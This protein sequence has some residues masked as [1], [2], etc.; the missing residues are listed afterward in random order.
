MIAVPCFARPIRLKFSVVISPS[1][2]SFGPFDSLPMSPLIWILVAALVV[3]GVIVLV[4]RS[5]A[6]PRVTS[7]ATSDLGHLLADTRR[8]L[9][10]R[11][12][13]VFARSAVS[14]S[15]WEE[16]EEELI[17]SDLGVEAARRIVEAVKR[18]GPVNARQAREVIRTEMVRILTGL[19]RSLHLDSKPAIVVMVGVNGVGKTT[20]VAKLAALLQAEGRH[21][22]IGAADTFRPAADTQLK[23]WADRVGV[24]VVSGQAGGDPAAVAY[25]TLQ[26]ARARGADVVIIDT[27]GRFQT[28]HN[29]MAELAKILRVL[30]KD[31][32]QVSEVLLVMDATTGQ[33]GLPQARRFAELGTTGMILTKMDGTSKGG[34][35][36]AVERELSLPVKFIGVGEGLE[37]LV[38]FDGAGFV[39][40]LLVAE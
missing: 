33:S 5:R 10:T 9:G 36:I 11:L 35:V 29:L 40:A 39:D 18:A 19:D 7:R 6:G 34:V 8:R 31:G 16:L 1:A 37:D 15:V 14:D 24:Q 20:T 21:P 26:A 30:A 23:V 32:D 25:D 22:I 4:W 17:S 28:R 13:S 3:A 2:H 27:A 38:P 12:E